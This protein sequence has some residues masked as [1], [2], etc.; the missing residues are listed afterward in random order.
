MPI[1]NKGNITIIAGCMSSAKT[2]TLI[3]YAKRFKIAKRNVVIIK[4]SDDN[5][6]DNTKD[7][8]THDNFKYSPDFQTDKLFNLDENQLELVEKS[9][10]ILIDEGHFFPDLVEFCDAYANE[11]KEIIVA[12]LDSDYLRQPFKPICDLVAKANQ[13]IKLKAVCTLC[14][15]DAIFT[16]RLVD[17]PNVKAVGGLEMYA[18]RCRECWYL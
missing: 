9:N 13:Y 3:S 2:T 6:Y 18:A 1:A 14:N 15:D 16:K 11:G 7:I 12:G 8:V 17:N 10:V 5:R 4:H